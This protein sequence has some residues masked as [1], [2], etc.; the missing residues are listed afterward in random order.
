MPD[1]AAIDAHVH[2]Y[3]SRE[4]GLQ[5]MS[6][7]GRTDYGGTPEELLAAMDRG[8]IETA[9]MVNMTPVLEM[10]EAAAS[11]LPPGLS[12]GQREQ[13]EQRIRHEMIGRLQRRNEWTCAVARARPR[14]VAFIGLDP[15]MSAGELVTEIDSRVSEGASGI[16]LH[17]PNQRFYPNDPRLRAA[18]VRMQ[19]LGLPVTFHSGAFALAPRAGDHGRA[20]HFAELL[21][22]FPRLTVVMAHLAF[23]DFD[24]CAELARTY[25]N[26]FF[27]CCFVVNGVDR[28]PAISDEEAVAAF[29]R[30]GTD[31]VMFGSDYPW[32]DPVADAG[33]IRRLPLTASE[34]RAILHDNA[35]RTL[36]L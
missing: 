6:G 20:E 19:E 1:I 21:A 15:A 8:G 9:V 2:T 10:F 3:R 34:K 13:E 36:G 11:K 31:R 16:K 12:P 24:A 28:P 7:A 30:I 5:A 33:R 29:R 22:A 4:V 18:Y 26:V 32:F 27:D 25:P 17:P 35:I 23:G 14:L